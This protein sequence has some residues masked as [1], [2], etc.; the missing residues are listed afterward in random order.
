MKNKLEFLGIKFNYDDLNCCLEFIKNTIN[1]NKKTYISTVNVGKLVQANRDEKLKNIINQSGLIT[2]D[3]MGIV[4]VINYFYKKK[5][6]RV[7]GIDILSKILQDFHSEI[8]F[9]GSKKSVLKD[10]INQIKLKHQNIIISGYNDGY[11][12]KDNDIVKK[13]NDS[14]AKILAI[15][16]TSPLQE[17]FIF[18]NFENL[19]VNISILVGGSFDVLSGNIKRAPVFMQKLAMEWVFRIFME[20]KRLFL[21]YLDTNFAYLILILKKLFQK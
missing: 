20:P 8:F 14:G 6:I 10:F 5:F 2:I 13:I 7:T 21:R 12:F 9:L 15:G 16:M 1:S 18:R 17:E 3:G 11:N 4:F 19:N